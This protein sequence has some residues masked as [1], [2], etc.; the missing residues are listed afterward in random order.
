MWNMCLPILHN[1]SISGTPRR[2][3]WFCSGEPAPRGGYDVYA[4][5]Y[6]N[7][8]GSQIAHLAESVNARYLQLLGKDADVPDDGYHGYDI[9]ETAKSLY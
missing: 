4:E 3:L 1:R 5:Y 7:D 9:V 6:V 2:G 8:A